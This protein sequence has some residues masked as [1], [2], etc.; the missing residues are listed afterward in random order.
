MWSFL[1]LALFISIKQFFKQT[2]MCVHLLL[3]RNSNMWCIS[4]TML[5]KCL[6]VI[7]MFTHVSQK[8]FCYQYKSIIIILNNN[9][10]QKRQSHRLR[11][12][13]VITIVEHTRMPKRAEMLLQ[14]FLSYVKTNKHS[15]S[16]GLLK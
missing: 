5:Y 15:K 6:F 8:L 4:F 16:T 7:E 3:P 13:G 12:H 2:F 11:H 1:L 9:M 10:H 14:H